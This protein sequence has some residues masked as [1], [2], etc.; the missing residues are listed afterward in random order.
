MLRTWL[1]DAITLDAEGALCILLL[2][3][4]QLQLVMAAAALVRAAHGMVP[5]RGLL[6][7][8]LAQTRSLVWI[9]F[10][11]ILLAGHSLRDLA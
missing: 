3:V 10:H 11:A 6:S 8:A 5:S 2:P 4:Q 9:F 7:P 1:L